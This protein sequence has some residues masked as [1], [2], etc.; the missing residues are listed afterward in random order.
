M[1]I[2]PIATVGSSSSNFSRNRC[3]IKAHFALTWINET[4]KKF[5]N[6]WM[7]VVGVVSV[8]ILRQSSFRSVSSEKT[9]ALLFTGNLS[10]R[11]L[12]ILGEC[13]HISLFTFYFYNFSFK[14]ILLKFKFLLEYLFYFCKMRK[15]RLVILPAKCINHVGFL[16]LF[17]SCPVIGD[18]GRIRPDSE[19]SHK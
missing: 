6:Q 8:Y 5:L 4:E 17:L 19:M 18:W 14:I 1:I 10:N 7:H 11:C 9:K 13:V 16:L 12:L 15:T 3:S 2:T